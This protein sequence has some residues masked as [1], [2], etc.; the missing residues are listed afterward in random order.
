VLTKNLNKEEQKMSSTPNQTPKRGRKAANV[1]TIGGCPIILPSVARPD[2]LVRD[3]VTDEQVSKFIYHTDLVHDDHPD[4]MTEKAAAELVGAKLPALRARCRKAL[5]N[6]ARLVHPLSDRDS[7]K[8]ITVSSPVARTA[9]S[10]VKTRR[11]HRDKAVVAAEKADL[12][13]KRDIRAKL[14]LKPKGRLDETAQAAFNVEYIKLGGTPA[15]A[16][17]KSKP[18][19]RV[20]DTATPSRGKGRPPGSKNRSKEEVAADKQARAIRLQA[21]SNLGLEN[22]GPIKDRDAFDAEVDKLTKAAK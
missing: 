16:K 11:P 9:D 12:Q 2:S 5:G 22:R 15:P 18:V 6:L 19:K 1:L 17:P 14:G 4:H 7:A 3:G 20:A 8:G 21:R 13:L 10:A